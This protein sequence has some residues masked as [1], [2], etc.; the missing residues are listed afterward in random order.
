MVES[1]KLAS[2]GAWM[3]DGGITQVAGWADDDLGVWADV[4]PMAHL[5]AKSTALDSLTVWSTACEDA[6]CFYI[7][8]H[9]GAFKGNY[10]GRRRA[11]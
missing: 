7:V 3:S 1:T 8:W 11:E 9:T 6:V 2:R 10:G 4:L 5:P